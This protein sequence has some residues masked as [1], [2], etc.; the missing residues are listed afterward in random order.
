MAGA[1]V[2][3]AEAFYERLTLAQHAVGEQVLA[4]IR[5]EPGR[6]ARLRAGGLDP[7][8]LPM[9][10]PFDLMTRPRLC[11]ALAAFAPRVVVAWAN[12]AGRFAGAVKRRGAPWTLVGRLG[13]YYDLKYY[14]HC[15]HLVGNTQ[16]LRDWLVRQ[17]W[18]AAR[19]HYVPN[20]AH[21]Y[22]G[23]APVALPGAQRLLALGRLHP[24]KGFD[25]LL[26][27]LARL[28]GAHLSLAGEGK[29][30][31]SLEHLARELGV[32][33]RVT[34]LGWR[35]DAGALLRGCD[36]FVC[37]SR[38]EPLGNVVL[39]AWSAGAPVVAAAA[40]GPV[41]LIRPGETGLLV[42][43]E[44][45]AALATAIAGLLANPARAAALAAA[46]RAE[47]ARAHAEAPVL[48][49]WREF[50]RSVA[51]EGARADDAP[52]GVPIHGEAR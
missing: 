43:K 4:V 16:D 39:E 52:D 41:E 13:G 3:G 8:E 14:R 40:Q 33:E 5:A 45:P 20:F 2:G 46:G 48:A 34:F 50:L 23:V 18:P 36:V 10:G 7:V 44:D 1:V 28:P 9:G 15:D 21:D 32:A 19:A 31:A 51:P 25:L 11:R 49:R 22:A 42:P 38:H 27:A 35:Q 24:N 29:E 6:A 47:F 12:R 26:H 17:G 37:P 30:R